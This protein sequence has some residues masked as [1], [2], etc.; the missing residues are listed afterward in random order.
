ML[1]CVYTARV[2]QYLSKDKRTIHR[3][4]LPGHQW[5]KQRGRFALL[6]LRKRR[7]LG[8]RAEQCDGT[9]K[10][11]KEKK[12]NKIKSVVLAFNLSMDGRSAMGWRE[13]GR[14]K[15]RRKRVSNERRS[16]HKVNRYGPCSSQGL[17][18][19]RTPRRL[20]FLSF[21][22][23]RAPIVP[24]LY[25]RPSLRLWLSLMLAMWIEHHSS[26]TKVCRRG[27]ALFLHSSILE[28]PSVAR[29]AS[30]ASLKL[31]RI[32]TRVRRRTKFLFFVSILRLRCSKGYSGYSLLRCFAKVRN[33]GSGI[34]GLLAVGNHRIVEFKMEK[35][36]SVV[37]HGWNW[38]SV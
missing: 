16:R 14:G 27:S 12:K 26:Q 29:F 17:T 9:N 31:P 23:P 19:L 13:T 10:K 18:A 1:H 28:L 3:I 33:C 21:S 4:S 36:W 32:S 11:R 8:K 5:N 2:E 35:R 25:Q 34:A 6:S 20:Y 15:T 22:F 38:S 30:L 7:F 24:S 37:S